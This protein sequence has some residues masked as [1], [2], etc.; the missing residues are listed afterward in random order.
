MKKGSSI[1]IFF[2]G[3]WVHLVAAA[4]LLRGITVKGA[5]SLQRQPDGGKE[6]VLKRIE[7]FIEEHG[8]RKSALWAAVPRSEILLTRLTL[9]SPVEENLTEAVGYELDR[10]TPYT[11]DETYFDCA[12]TGRDTEAGTINVVQTTVLKSS[13]A[14]SLDIL[15]ETGLLLTSVEPSSTAAANAF[16]YDAG[17][18][19]GRYLFVSFSLEGFE[20]IL[21]D[22]G[23]FTYS[24]YFHFE[25][26]AEA[27]PP[28]EKLLEKIIE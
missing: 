22:D 5:L 13:L 6:E 16:L 14:P 15:K 2:D 7:D 11:R 12:I 19:A 1:G 26:S 17:M 10:N 27:K 4:R 8:T 18:E 24:R 3:E 25:S 9:P 28:L 21:I 20:L 23:V